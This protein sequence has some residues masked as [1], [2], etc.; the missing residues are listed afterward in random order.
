MSKRARRASV[1][2][3]LRPSGCVSGARRAVSSGSRPGERS[4]QSTVARDAS[5][6]QS[7][8]MHPSEGL[9]GLARA[10]G[11]SLPPLRQPVAVAAFRVPRRPPRPRLERAANHVKHVAH[12]PRHCR[13]PGPTERPRYERSVIGRV[14]KHRGWKLAGADESAMSQVPQTHA[15]RAGQEGRMDTS[16]GNPETFTEAQCQLRRNTVTVGGTPSLPPACLAGRASI[17]K[18]PRTRAASCRGAEHGRVVNDPHE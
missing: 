15:V 11:R 6:P 16:R 9:V 5:T 17:R 12:T 4:E 7:E 18:R 8:P 10:A 14:A 1:A 2:V 13:S 3:G